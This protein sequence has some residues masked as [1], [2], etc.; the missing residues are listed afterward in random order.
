MDQ[1][2]T[3]ENCLLLIARRVQG[4]PEISFDTQPLG[5]IA[6]DMERRDMRRPMTPNGLNAVVCMKL[7]REPA[8]KIVRLADVD[9]PERTASQVAAE[10]IDA[11]LREVS[12]SE[13]VKLELVDS[14][15]AALPV[16][17]N[18]RFGRTCD[19]HS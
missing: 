16:D 7:V 18:E 11:R 2:S 19:S 12:S 4:V 6:G 8:A 10:D 5:Q 17:G 13:R 14:P 15:A 9:C 1:A 3:R